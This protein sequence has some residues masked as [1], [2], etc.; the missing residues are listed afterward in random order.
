MELLMQDYFNTCN[1][2]IHSNWIVSFPLGK[3]Q[4]S[5]ERV[6]QLSHGSVPEDAIVTLTP[7]LK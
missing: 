6:K 4:L 7:V 2:Q 1:L 3:G 5:G